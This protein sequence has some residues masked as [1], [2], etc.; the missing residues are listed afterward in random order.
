LS[1]G[2]PNVW[3]KIAEEK[4]LKASD[5]KLLQTTLDDREPILKRTPSANHI[6]DF[7]RSIKTGQES[8]VGIS[9]AVRS[10]N[11]SQLCDI[12]VRTKSV[13]KWDPVKLELV[14]AT[15]EQKKIMNRA[16]V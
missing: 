9:D 14:D 10:D 16:D 2:D 1:G 12:A 4:G 15:D 5:P 6:D 8:V 13:V 7:I 3:G 11:I